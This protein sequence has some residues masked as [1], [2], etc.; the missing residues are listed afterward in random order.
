MHGTNAYYY[1]PTGRGKLEPKWE[2]PYIIEKVYSNG[3]YLLIT[4]DD[5]QIIP[6]TN[7]RFLKYY[8]PFRKKLPDTSLNGPPIMYYV[9]LPARTSINCSWQNQTD[10]TN[11][12]SGLKE[13]AYLRALKSFSLSK[14]GHIAR[15]LNTGKTDYDCCKSGYPFRGNHTFR[16]G[17]PHSEWLTASL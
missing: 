6:P 10:K 13:K 3:A 11:E 1:Q 15:V 2:G 5:E 12:R 16:K 17:I 14:R 4:M 7:A 9:I 8:Y